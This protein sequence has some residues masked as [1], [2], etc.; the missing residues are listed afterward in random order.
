MGVNASICNLPLQFVLDVCADYVFETV[1]GLKSEITR[2]LGVETL[3]PAGNNALDKFVRCAA[4]ARGDI[5]AGY[6]AERFDLF[7]DRARYAGH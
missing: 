2:T 4:D 3:G 6:A 5:V 7:S 1:F